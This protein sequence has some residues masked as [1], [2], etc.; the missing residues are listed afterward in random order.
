MRR[1]VA[2]FVAVL[3]FR[4]AA[5]AQYIHVRRDEVPQG[6]APGK[7]RYGCWVVAFERPGG[8]GRYQIDAV[9]ESKRE[10][11]DLATKLSVSGR[12][13]EREGGRVGVLV[14]G[15]A[16]V[17]DG[18]PNEQVVFLKSRVADMT[19]LHDKLTG[20]RQELASMYARLPPE[21]VMSVNDSIGRY[22][23]LRDDVARRI[24]FYVATA[25]AIPRLEPPHA[26][27]RV[28]ARPA[29][30]RR[31]GCGWSWSGRGR[32]SSVPTSSRSCS[33]WRRRPA[34]AR[35]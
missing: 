19:A 26:A 33:T 7:V 29:P 1:T 28:P 20:D 32:A 16:Y 6:T 14:Y 2:A 17:G 5:S 8:S 27:R 25:P 21:L 31:C 4:E 12:L 34:T 13:P 22:N 30:T 35:R 9:T 15:M 10:A 23:T 18:T 24:G 3:A 11:L